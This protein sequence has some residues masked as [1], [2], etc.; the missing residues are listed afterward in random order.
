[1]RKELALAPVQVGVL[2]AM[3][4]AVAILSNP[5]GGWLAARIGRVKPLLTTKLIFLVG[6]LLTA[7]GSNFETVFAGRTLVG[8]A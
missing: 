1:M 3:A 4:P 2:T 5:F 7:V 6:A 8:I